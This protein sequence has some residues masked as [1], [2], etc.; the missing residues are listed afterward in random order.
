MKFSDYTGNMVGGGVGRYSNLTTSRSSSQESLSGNS[1]TA[2]A[3]VELYLIPGNTYSAIGLKNSSATMDPSLSNDYSYPTYAWTSYSGSGQKS[4]DFGMKFEGVSICACTN[5]SSSLESPQRKVFALHSGTTGMTIYPAHL[6]YGPKYQQ[7]STFNSE[8][9]IGYSYGDIN[10]WLSH[11]SGDGKKYMSITVNANNKFIGTSISVVK[12]KK[13]TFNMHTVSEE[14]FDGIIISTSSMTSGNVQNSGVARCSG[15]NGKVD[16]TY[17]AKNNGTIY[18]YFKTDGSTLTDSSTNFTTGDIEIT[19]ELITTTVTLN[20]NGATSGDTSF[21]ITYGTN[22]STISV[23]KPTG[24]KSCNFEG[25]YTGSS[26]TSPGTKYIDFSGTGVSGKTW[27]IAEETCTLYA[28]YNYTQSIVEDWY[29]LHC[30]YCTSSAAA[31]S[32]LQAAASITLGTMRQPLISGS[33]SYSQ[34]NVNAANHLG[35]LTMPDD[36]TVTIPSGKASGDYKFEIKYTFTPNDTAV[37]IKEENQECDIWIIPTYIVDETM[38]L[39]NISSNLT[40]KKDIPAGSFTLNVNNLSEY[41]QYPSTIPS[42]TQVIYNNGKTESST[43]QINW[44]INK[45]IIFDSLGSTI[46]NRQQVTI[47]NNSNISMKVPRHTYN[48]DIYSTGSTVIQIVSNAL[49]SS[50]V[51][52][53]SR[54]EDL[55]IRTTQMEKIVM[56]LES[57][58]GITIDNFELNEVYSVD[59]LCKYLYKFHNVGSVSSNQTNSYFINA[60][61]NS[62]KVYREANEVTNLHISVSKNPIYVDDTATL[63]TTADFTSGSEGVSVNG[64][65]TFSDYKTSIISIDNS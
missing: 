2:T 36:E 59:L 20:R 41:F 6:L 61:Y 21:N 25:Y 23:T 45:S 44:S 64:L 13:Y 46:T 22:V 34:L 33:T 42:T 17:V 52:Y 62:T 16:Y 56:N 9:Y 37:F 26:R 29:P 28:F 35:N 58:F 7:A 57:E 24:K 43:P 14:N 48:G 8:A 5:Q 55:G 12:G 15:P 27:D 32:T 19:E 63:N 54:F 4:Y 49:G 1:T 40:Q 47:P 31:A 11:T 65:E 51:D 3:I 60:S 30:V 18:I 50:N 38:T 39:S 53:H 10:T